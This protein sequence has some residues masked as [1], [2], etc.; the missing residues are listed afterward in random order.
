MSEPTRHLRFPVTYRIEHWV[1]MG[2]FTILAITGLVQK[3]AASQISVT[4]IGW[5]GGIETVRIIHRAAA[6]VLLLEVVYHLGAVG[7]RLFVR[8][9]RP[10]MLPSLDDVSNAWQTLRYNFGAEERRPQQ[11]RYTFEEKAEY[12]AFVWGTVVMVI[13]GFFMWNPIATTRF[14]PGQVIPAAKAAHGNEALLAVLAIILWHMYH[15]HIRRFNRSM[16]SGYMS[17]EVMLDEHPIELADRKAGLDYRPQPPER[18]RRRRLIFAPI[19]GVLAAS[20]LIGIFLFATFEQTAIETVPPPAEAGP[21]F[22]PFTA[23][24][25][26]TAAP[27]QPPL[28]GS[29]EV[30]MPTS[31]TDGMGAL[32]ASRCGAC[33]GGESPFGGLSVASYDQALEGGVSGPGIVPA[34]P[35]SS[36]IVQRQARGDHPGQFTGQELDWIR[37]WIEAGAPE[38]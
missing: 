7:Y 21:A 29:S 23:T 35:E 28:A 6:I 3:F 34:E 24:P 37:Q 1:S 17:E 16:F 25:E 14:L 10:E 30:P 15:V 20:M 2:S 33:H 18:I 8:R 9:G 19:Y 38:G 22:V 11:G 27:T 13:T 5:M 4:L 26:P 31:W 32:F 36:V 12:W